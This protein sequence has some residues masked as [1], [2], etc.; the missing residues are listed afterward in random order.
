M[1]KRS[2]VKPVGA[3][4]QLCRPRAVTVVPHSRATSQKNILYI[5]GITEDDMR[6]SAG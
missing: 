3:G 5:P 1:T 4:V 2:A 6:E